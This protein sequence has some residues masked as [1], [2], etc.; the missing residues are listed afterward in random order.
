MDKYRFKP[1]RS[2]N[3]YQLGEY[4]VG[5]DWAECGDRTAVTAVRA[6]VGGAECVGSIVLPHGAEIREVAIMD[7]S[8]AG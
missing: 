2:A 7:E 3:C 4:T 8:A 1:I 5:I 6:S